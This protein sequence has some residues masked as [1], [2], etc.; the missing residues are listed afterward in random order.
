MEKSCPAWAQTANAANSR[1]PSFAKRMYIKYLDQSQM[2][3]IDGIAANM[4]AIK[5]DMT[6]N[7]NLNLTLMNP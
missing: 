2:N 3:Q 1:I 7:I 4:A 6:S 5:V